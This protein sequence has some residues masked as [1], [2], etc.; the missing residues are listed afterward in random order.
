MMRTHASFVRMIRG[1]VIL[2][3]VQEHFSSRRRTGARWRAGITRERAFASGGNNSVMRNGIRN[4]AFARHANFAAVDP[5]E[6]AQSASAA[7]ESLAALIHQLADLPIVPQS[8]FHAVLIDKLDHW[9]AVVERPAASSAAKKEDLKA[10]ADQ[11][12]ALIQ[13]LSGLKDDLPSEA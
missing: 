6:L 1:G 4:A 12:E 7:V 13:L 9:R 5:T 8:R 2:A 3:A 10:V 11:L